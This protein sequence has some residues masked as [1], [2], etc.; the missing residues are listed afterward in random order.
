MGKRRHNQDKMWISNKEMQTDWGGKN[1]DAERIK[2]RQQLI[3]L[4][5]DYCN[6][7]MTPFRDPYATADGVIFDLLN[8]V[9]YLRK[10]GRNPM[11]GEPMQQSD[12]IK[13]NFHKNEAGE[14]HC[15]V[16][17]KT[18]TEHSHIVAVRETGNVYSYS[19]YLELNKQP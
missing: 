10:H 6:I 11:S 7:S 1:T 3:K 15:P 4:P 18:F 12:L 14:Y 8:I 13:L 19:A 5:Y 17:Y 2:Q 16:T 9:P